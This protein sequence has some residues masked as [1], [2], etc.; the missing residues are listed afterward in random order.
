MRLLH[1]GALL[2]CLAGF[3][4]LISN[5]PAQSHVC[6]NDNT[7]LTVPR[8]FL[9]LCLPTVSVMRVTWWCLPAG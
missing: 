4:F 5:A 1:I 3:A 8:G 2:R 9:P 6:P 7:G